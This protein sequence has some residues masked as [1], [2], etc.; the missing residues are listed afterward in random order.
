VALADDA[1]SPV[2]DCVSNQ[3]DRTEIDTYDRP[4]AV[5]DEGRETS[6]PN[7]LSLQFRIRSRVLAV[8]KIDENALGRQR[9]SD[10]GGSQVALLTLLSEGSA[11][12]RQLGF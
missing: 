6:F 8:Q 11:A 9:A 2:V 7:N 10:L 3:P 12:T 1:A 4:I 5:N